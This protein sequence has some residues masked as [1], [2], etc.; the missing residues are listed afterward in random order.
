MHDASVRFMLKPSEI[1]DL[2]SFALSYDIWPW[3][4]WDDLVASW[5]S[6]AHGIF[7]Q[8]GI[9]EQEWGGS[10]ILSVV[11][12]VFERAE[13][14]EASPPTGISNDVPIY[15]FIRPL[16]RPCDDEKRWDAWLKGSKYFWSFDCSGSDEIP[17]HE[18]LKL[19]LPFLEADLGVWHHSWDRDAYD[20]LE[21]IHRSRRFDPT[22]AELARSLRRLILEVVGDDARFK[23]LNLKNSNDGVDLRQTQRFPMTFPNRIQWLRMHRSSYPYLKWSPQRSQELVGIID[24]D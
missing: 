2:G 16:P 3:Q 11:H 9:G 19:G 20:V 14:Q 6:Q 13:A 22:S 24:I 1:K 7:G 8:L 4:T 23:E 12:L 18:R 17:D 21:M 10:S 5:L 15:L